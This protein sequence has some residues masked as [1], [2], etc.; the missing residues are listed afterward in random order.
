MVFANAALGNAPE[1][2]ARFCCATRRVG[3]C[4]TCIISLLEAARGND[5]S[6]AWFS[7]LGAAGICGPELGFGLPDLCAE[8][9][10]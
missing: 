10:S 9:L 6:F 3:R 1:S 5:R 2:D 4:R 8:S 7:I